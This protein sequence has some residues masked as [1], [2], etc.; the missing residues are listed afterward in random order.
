MLGL[1]YCEKAD[2]LDWLM[3]GER[4]TGILDCL[5]Y[6][7]AKTLYIKLGFLNPDCLLADLP[8]S[9][10]FC[11]NISMSWLVAKNGSTR[12]P[13]NQVENFSQ[14]SKFAALVGYS[15]I[16]RIPQIFSIRKPKALY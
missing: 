9:T 1:K 7:R 5:D 10:V 16:S 3:T 11:R 12:W 4:V 15:C 2:V 6:G 14:L 13:P 8:G